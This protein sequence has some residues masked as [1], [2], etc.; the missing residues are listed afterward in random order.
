MFA[1]KKKEVIKK[2]FELQKE[3]EEKYG[4]DCVVL[5]ELGKFL[6]CFG[7]PENDLNIPVI[8]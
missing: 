8:G 2:Y 4:K 5:Y 6:E 1:I 3:F 7:I